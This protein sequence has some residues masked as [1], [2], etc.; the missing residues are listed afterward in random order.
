MR[1]F[2]EGRKSLK[3]SNYSFFETEVVEVISEWMWVLIIITLLALT[4]TLIKA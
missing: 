3:K 1:K 4:A 2:L